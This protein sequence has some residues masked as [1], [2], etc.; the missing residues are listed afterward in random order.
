MKTR[1]RKTK[2][3][4]THIS[5]RDYRAGSNPAGC[6]DPI[7]SAVDELVDACRMSRGCAA[8]AMMEEG[9]TAREDLPVHGV[10]HHM[11]TGESLILALKN[12]GHPITEELV[13]EI[14]D[15]GKQIPRGSCGFMGT[16]G[17]ITSAIS[18]CALL[19]GATPAATGAR[20]RT[21]AF[22]A[23]LTARL[24]ELSGSRCCKKSTYIALQLARDEFAALGFEFP[25]ET[26]EGRCRFSARNETCDGL[27]CLFYQDSA[28]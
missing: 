26:Y 9:L 13:E 10:W 18:T 8:A 7:A 1:T 23:K 3:K 6:A 17:A 27:E 14:V 28:Q 20:A 15:R 4:L 22:A 19:T 21:L 24:A 16:C 11:L 12:A 2:S 25:A 5:Y